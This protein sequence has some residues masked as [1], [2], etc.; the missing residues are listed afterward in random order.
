M[1]FNFL[2]LTQKPTGSVLDVE[3]DRWVPPRIQK[4]TLTSTRENEFC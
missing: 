3:V 1:G 4:A 2:N